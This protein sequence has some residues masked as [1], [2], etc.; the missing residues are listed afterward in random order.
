MVSAAEGID[1]IGQAAARQRIAFNAA[2]QFG[3]NRIED[4]AGVI[5]ADAGNARPSAPPFAP[6][7]ALRIRSIRFNRPL[8]LHAGN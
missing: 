4:G 1:N 7:P 8:R 2:R 6:S 5:T 3:Q